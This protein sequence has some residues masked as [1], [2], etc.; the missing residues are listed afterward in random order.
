MIYFFTDHINECSFEETTS[1]K[2]TGFKIELFKELS[3]EDQELIILRSKKDIDSCIYIC[4]RHKSFFLTKNPNNQRYCCNPFNDHSETIINSSL[5]VI[6]LNF[7]N[8]YKNIMNANGIPGN[9]ICGKCRKIAN[10]KGIESNECSQAPSDELS[11]SATPNESALEIFNSIL[12]KAG[13]SPLK[14]KG[15]RM[16]AKISYGR[17]KLNKLTLVMESKLKKSLDL[18]DSVVLS[19]LSEQLQKSMFFDTMMSELKN[20]IETSNNKERLQLLTLLP[21][22]MSYGNI[23]KTLNVSNR[24][25]NNA[26][27]LKKLH[28]FFAVP[29]SKKGVPLSEEIL[30]RVNN[31]YCDYLY[32]RIMPNKKDVIKISK[33][34]FRAKR[35]LLLNFKELYAEYKKTYPNDKIGFT[36]FFRLKPIQCITVDSSG[37]HSICVCP[38][39]QNFDLLIK[40]TGSSLSYKDEICKAVCNTNNKNCMFRI[41][42]TCPKE[43]VVKDRLQELFLNINEEDSESEEIFEYI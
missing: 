26:K 18:P 25:I 32:S 31:F 35:L 37:S 10:C 22:D 19:N 8:N 5:R 2:C 4:S 39:H 30:N 16:D 9:K 27:N 1:I 17:K 7:Y 40:A 38:K 43:T 21:D 42:S 36:T 24:L 6:S 15:G 3:I 34:E 20:K 11:P 14:L 12:D 23:K 29:K 13:L 28:G 33:T 41:C